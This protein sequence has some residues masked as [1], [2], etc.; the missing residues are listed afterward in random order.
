MC[1]KGDIHEPT[2][3]WRKTQCTTDGIER[4]ASQKIANDI[5][6]R[7]ERPDEKGWVETLTDIYKHPEIRS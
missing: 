4:D 1:Q 3:L 7:F 5:V 2:L 6:E